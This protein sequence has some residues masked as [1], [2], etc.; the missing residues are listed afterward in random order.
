MFKRTLDQDIELALIQE[1]FAPYYSQIVSEQSEYLAQWLAWPPHCQSEQDFRLFA[2]RMLHDY[3]DGKSM[4][5]AIF[6][7]NELVGNCSFNRINYDTRCVE[8]GYWLSQ[9]Y[10]GKGIMTRVVKHL[11]DIAF[12]ELDMDK[13]QLS[14]AVGNQASRQVAERAGMVLEGIVT[15]QE[16]IADRIL[17]HAI[18]GLKKAQ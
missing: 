7:R 3:A 18:Y 16:K 12:N 8:I 11:I 14:A 2:Q 5:C 4:T 15:N 1:S 17:D 6:Y 13:V 10:Q 9:Y